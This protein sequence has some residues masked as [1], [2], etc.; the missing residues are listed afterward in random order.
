[1]KHTVLEQVCRGW[2]QHDKT[3]GLFQPFKLPDGCMLYRK[4]VINTIT[5]SIYPCIYARLPAAPGHPIQNHETPWAICSSSRKEQP[6][7]S[8]SRSIFSVDDDKLDGIMRMEMYVGHACNAQRTSTIQVLGD[9]TTGVFTLPLEII[10]VLHLHKVR[11][12]QTPSHYLAN[13]RRLV[14]RPLPDF[15][16]LCRNGSTPA[17]VYH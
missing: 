17:G 3:A 15:P 14:S 5:L 10:E 7:S 12:N 16:S 4:D 9:M 8:F 11:S 13:H 1:M 6:V 2:K